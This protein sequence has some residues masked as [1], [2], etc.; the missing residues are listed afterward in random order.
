[1]YGDFRWMV[2]GRVVSI[3]SSIF[4]RYKFQE[5]Q[6]NGLF[7]FDGRFSCL[8]RQEFINTSGGDEEMIKKATDGGSG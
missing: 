8:D 7:D 4:L 1:M 5:L 6:R 3:L 2:D